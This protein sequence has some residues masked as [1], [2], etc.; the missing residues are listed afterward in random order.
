MREIEIH[1]LTHILRSILWRG[2]EKYGIVLVGIVCFV[3]LAPQHAMGEM[4][5]KKKRE[6]KKIIYGFLL[7]D[8]GC[9]SLDGGGEKAK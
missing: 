2:E 5:K 4:R 3:L 6:G 1:F 9:V 7:N 8:D